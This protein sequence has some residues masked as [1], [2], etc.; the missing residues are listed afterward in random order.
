[1]QSTQRKWGN[2]I[3]LRKTHIHIPE[4]L[5]MERP[6]IFV[7]MSFLPRLIYYL[8]TL[9][10]ST[11]QFSHSVMS[12]SLQAH[13]LQH[14]R[15]PCLSPTHGAYSNSCPLRWWCHPKILSSVILLSSFLQSL[16]SFIM[17]QSSHQVG[18]VLELQ[19]QHQS[20]CWIFRI[21][22]L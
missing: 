14:A 1:M 17:S 12:N 20:F 5:T 10:F 22:F 13:G 6:L 15:L 2:K 7:K 16:G 19:L 8:T 4:S 3:L 11:V 9:M 18:K 21:D